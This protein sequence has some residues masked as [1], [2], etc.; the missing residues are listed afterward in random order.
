RVLFRSRAR[1]DRLP[2]LPQTLLAPWRH[3]LV[4]K[5]FWPPASET[6]RSAP[7]H[8]GLPAA[9]KDGSP[10][11]TGNVL[12]QENTGQRRA[13]PWTAS[14]LETPCCPAI[15][16]FSRPRRSPTRCASKRSHIGHQP[17]SI[18]PARF[19]GVGTASRDRHHGYQNVSPSIW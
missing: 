18:A 5:T 6:L 7:K 14:L 17:R 9:L 2:W 13:A 3:R 4:P 8:F 16:T 15:S 19:H 11:E 12:G 10:V 1:S